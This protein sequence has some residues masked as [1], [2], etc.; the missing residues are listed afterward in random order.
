MEVKLIYFTLKDSFIRNEILF[1]TKISYDARKGDYYQDPACFL[2]DIPSPNE[3][4]I[5]EM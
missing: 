5:Q 3:I 1:R 4:D 2:Q